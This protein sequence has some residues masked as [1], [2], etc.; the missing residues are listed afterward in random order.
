MLPVLN[1]WQTT[2]IHVRSVIVLTLSTA[3][4]LESVREKV[5]DTATT[6]INFDTSVGH[7]E[8]VIVRQTG[9]ELLIDQKGAHYTGER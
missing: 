2:N 6:T 5:A 3:D 9:V 7:C 4:L 8:S 1:P